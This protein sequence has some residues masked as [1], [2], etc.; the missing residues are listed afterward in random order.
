L[1]SIL[2]K[3]KSDGTIHTYPR[4]AHNPKF[5]DIKLLLE[6]VIG[7]EVHVQLLTRTKMFCACVSDSS[8]GEPNTRVC[9][10]CL[11]L[12][13]VLPVVNKRAVQFTVMTGLALNSTIASDTKFDRK[14][15]PYPDLM[16]GYQI[17][18][19]DIPIASGGWLELDSGN[20]LGITRVHMEEDTA[21][22]IHRVDDATGKG[23]SLVDVNRSGIPLMEIVGD[24]DI[25]SADDAREYL[26][27]L[28]SIVQYL[29]V[30]T[31]NMEEGS[32][33]C[34]ANISLKIDGQMSDQRV[35]VK[36]MNSFRAVHGALEYE[37]Q[38]Q[39]EVL[40]KGQRIVQETR[41]WIEDQGITVSQRSK[42]E[43]HDYRYFP[44]PDLPPLVVD[45]IWV[46]DIRSK[47]PELPENRRKRFQEEYDLSEYDAN[48]LVATK[49]SAD[50]FE[51]S[52]STRGDK[53]SIESAIAKSTA[54]WINTDLAHLLNDAGVNIENSPIS[55]ASLSEMLAFIEDGT[56]SS[57]MAKDLFEEMFHTEKGAKVIIEAKGLNQISDDDA[58][59]EFVSGVIAEN[60]KAVDDYRNGKE[61]A[62]KF[63]VGQ[64]MRVTRGQAN[65]Q[66]ATEAV[67]SQ[68]DR[69]V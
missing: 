53:Q 37:I 56:I 41:G 38:R 40:E 62:V 8:G 3:F 59:A 31:G 43:A 10:V 21:R 11:G 17:S 64:V 52:L 30:S 61:T 50:F 69:D 7:L 60:S 27:K 13:G 23:F 55:P 25:S 42:E 63:L 24:P 44:E 4:W 6:P 36:N 54:N 2:G 57:K 19:F 9:P 33:R 67:L 15:Y 1:I 18:Q 32:F 22:L 16:K 68:L 20:R 45:P 58:L 26:T 49:A 12:P 14:N 39:T 51:D 47:L 46:E 28:R 29:G 48:Q 34:D 5:E 66:K 35:E 65:P